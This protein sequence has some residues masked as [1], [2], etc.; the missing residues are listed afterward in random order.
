MKEKE[1]EK[2]ATND[3]LLDLSH[4]LLVERNLDQV[5]ATAIDGIIEITGAERGMII[6]FAQNGE[7]EFQTARNLDKEDVEK[8]SFEISNTIIETVRSTGKPIYL[9]NALE[10][11]K[12]E[13]SKSVFT[14][15]ILS[16][17]CLPLRQGDSLFGLLYL[18]NRTVRGAFKESNY[19]F[20]LRF[21]D[22]ITAA[23]FNALERKQLNSNVKNLQKELSEKY[24]FEGI[25]GDSVRMQEI[26]KLVSQV[27]DTDATILIQGES[28]TGKEMIARSLH[29]NSNRKDMPFIAINCGAMPE[30]LLESEMFGHVKGAFTG[31]NQDKIG[32]FERANSGTIF[33]DEVSE[34]SSALQVKLLRILQTGEYARVGT[35]EMKHC[36]VRILAAS[37]KNLQNLLK[38]ERFREDLYYRLNVINIQVPPLRE[39]KSDI[40]LLAEYFL[41]VYNVKH[42]KSIISISQAAM[43][44]FLSYNFP[45][46]VRELE[47]IIQHAVILSNESHIETHHLPSNVFGL[48]ALI[49]EESETFPKAKKRVIENFEKAFI[50]T[51]L[52]KSK[53]NISRAA[54]ISGVHVK[55]FFEKMKKYGINARE[56]G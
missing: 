43:S 19:Q 18:D 46:N 30:S 29:F 1:K 17:I 37:N 9:E 8:P 45:G 3:L 38:E 34:M 28:G 26:L 48:E 10:D 15:H 36:D 31:A 7:T 4:K 33:L 14:L 50:T 39:R 16:V 40:P 51:Q 11:P 25:V 53:G 55:N 24:S 20:A 27:A 56:F 41:Q 21:A 2:I 12:F 52:V 6:F 23:A 32:W 44:V 54:K 13:A 22:F 47:N 49:G 35:S 42:S 5:L